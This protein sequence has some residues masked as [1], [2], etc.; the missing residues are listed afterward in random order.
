MGDPKRDYDLDKNHVQPYHDE[1]L[2][3]MHSLMSK[4]MEKVR[5]FE[6]GRGSPSCNLGIS[7]NCL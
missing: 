5:G 6:L 4:R 7:Y 1:L 2:R 3:L